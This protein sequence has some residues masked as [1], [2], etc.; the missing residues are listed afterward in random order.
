MHIPPYYKKESWQRF[1]AGTFVGAIIAFVVFMYM[2]GQLYEGWVEENLELRSQLSDSKAKYK[3]LEESNKELD[4]RYQK[5]ATISSI[6][7]HISNSEQLDL[8][9]LIIREFEEAIKNEIEDAIGQEIERISE[10][11]SFVIRSI[12]NKV[13]S[14]DGFAYQAKVDHLFIMETLEIHVTLKLAN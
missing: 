7:I 8:D 6:Q 13:F 12:E 4:Q 14:I 3:A 1:L 11:Y 9:P 5:Q 2:Y 10:S